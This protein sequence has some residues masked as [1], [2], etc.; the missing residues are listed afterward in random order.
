MIIFILIVQKAEQS[1]RTCHMYK[2]D[3]HD[4][5]VRSSD[6]KFVFNATNGAIELDIQ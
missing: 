6:S 2:V 5:F 4:L 1:A 3:F